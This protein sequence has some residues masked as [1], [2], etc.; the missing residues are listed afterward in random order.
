MA[1]TALSVCGY[2]LIDCTWTSVY[3]ITSELFPT[4][5]RNTGQGTG[6]TSARIGGIL[7]PY[8]ALMGTLPG[9]SI[10]FPVVTFAVVATLAGIL[11]Y[12]IPETLFSAMHQTIEEAEAAKDD[13][14]IPCCG[15]RLN[16]QRKSAAEENDAIKMEDLSDEIIEG[17]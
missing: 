12:W 2:N 8:V 3:L 17:D 16:R 10:A 15:R 1:T 14:G 7:A 11:M 13:Y 4:V 5:L 9:L 6:S